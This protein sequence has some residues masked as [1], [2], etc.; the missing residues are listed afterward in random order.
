MKYQHPQEQAL[1]KTHSNVMPLQGRESQRKAEAPALC[2]QL[3]RDTF[4]V[5]LDV[6]ARGMACC[7]RLAYQLLEM[8][9]ICGG[10][11]QCRQK[12]IELR[13]TMSI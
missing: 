7:P 5:H 11:T 6:A 10:T 3:H 4:E 13:P 9:Q 2:K 12:A 8:Q 1:I